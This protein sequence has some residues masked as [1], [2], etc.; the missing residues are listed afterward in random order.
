MASK[1]TK[2]E[3]VAL[4]S[5]K[6]ARHFGVIASDASRSQIYKTVIMTVRDM[7]AE[8]RTEFKVQSTD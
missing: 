4:L 6:L 5:G 7:L 1:M 2:K 8:K 3:V